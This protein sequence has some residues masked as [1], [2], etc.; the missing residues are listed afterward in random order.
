MQVLIMYYTRSGNTEKLAREIAKGV[1]QV[2]G[3][4]CLVKP[5]AEVTKD[6]FINS[7]GIIA[8]SPVYF[9]SMAAELKQVFDKLV[10]VRDGMGSK[11]GAAFATSGD[12]SG[13]KETTLISIIQAMLI[14]GMIIVG[15]PLDATGHYGV[16]CCGAPDG[17]TC[18]NGV[19]LGRRVAELVKKII[20]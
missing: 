20:S 18:Q 1:G 12:L 11:V 17:N 4:K 16:S 14:Y 3:V 6:D 19:K 10:E 8:G 13:G 15:D 2:K 9:G 5:A 7:D